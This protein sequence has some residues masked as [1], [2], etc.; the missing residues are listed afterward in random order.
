MTRYLGEQGEIISCQM[1]STGQMSLTEL[2]IADIDDGDI[3]IHR[4]GMGVNIDG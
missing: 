3:P 4:F 1:K 2:Q